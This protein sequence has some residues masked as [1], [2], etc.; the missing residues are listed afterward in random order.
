MP[1]SIRGFIR[2]LAAMGLVAIVSLGA[3]PTPG[4]AHESVPAIVTAEVGGPESLELRL[5]VNLEAIIAGIGRDH[6]AANAAATEYYERLR[7]ASPDVL[8]TAFSEIAD[9]FAQGLALRVDGSRADLALR[10]ID[11]PPVGDT[12]LPRVSTVI[13]V[14]PLSPSAKVMTWQADPMLGETVFRA[15]RHGTTDPVYSAFLA[16]GEQTKP[17]SLE[18]PVSE[19]HWSRFLEYLFVGFEHIVPKGYDHILFVIGLFLLSPHFRALG[20]QVTAFTLAHS[21]TL[22]LGVLGLVQLPASIVEPLIAASIVFIAVENLF[23]DRLKRWRPLV[24]FGFGLIHGLGFAGVLAETGFP[25]SQIASALAGFNVGVEIA[26]LAIIGACFL[27]AG[28]WFRSRAWYR[29]VISMPASVAIACIAI[30]WVIERT[31]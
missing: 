20:W 14:G 12:A 22:G 23:T 8:R 30:F 24:I 10:G 26:Q 5:A 18:A 31:V 28:L 27:F 13:L 17:V 25:P 15:R 21:V 6:D 11:I 4:W 16:A 29:A 19:S 7:Q 3:A 1:T 2:I 9:G